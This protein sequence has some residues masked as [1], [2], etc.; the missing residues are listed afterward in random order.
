MS[1]VPRK[2]RF[3]VPMP[4][5]EPRPLPVRRPEAVPAEHDRWV[6]AGPYEPQPVQQVIHVHEAAQ[7]DRVLQ[8]LALGAGMG[9]GATFAAV[10]LGPLLVA[11][12][13]LMVI[14]LLAGGLVIGVMA[15]AVV[16]VVGSLKPEPRGRRRR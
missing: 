2:Y 3:D 15:W 4:G 1:A 12:M 5:S 10:Y 7:P 9:L 8:R 16:S 6:P 13:E 14:T 11:S